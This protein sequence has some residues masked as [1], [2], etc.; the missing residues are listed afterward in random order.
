VEKPVDNV[1]NSVDFTCAAAERPLYC[2]FSHAESANIL[3]CAVGLH[4]IIVPKV[5]LCGCRRVM[6]LFVEVSV[7]ITPTI[8]T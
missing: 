3:S 4:R 2:P 7:T 6:D 5:A 8:K 1:Q